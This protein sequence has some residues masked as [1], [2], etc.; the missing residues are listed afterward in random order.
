MLQLSCRNR[1]RWHGM[2]LWWLWHHLLE[3]LLEEIVSSTS[4]RLCKTDFVPKFCTYLPVF[5][6]PLIIRFG[7]YNG[8][9]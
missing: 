2:L 7:K 6:L 9:N 8:K 5:S 1:K 3:V 4:E